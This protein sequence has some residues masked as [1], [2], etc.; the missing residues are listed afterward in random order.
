MIQHGIRVIQAR[1]RKIPEGWGRRRNI[2]VI[3]CAFLQKPNM[4]EKWKE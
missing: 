3:I 4:A 1:E 2:K